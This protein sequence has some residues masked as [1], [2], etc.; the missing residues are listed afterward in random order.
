MNSGIMEATRLVRAGRVAEATALIQHALRAGAVTP[1]RPVDE[2]DAPELAKLIRQ[3]GVEPPAA[4]EPPASA[5]PA[6]EKPATTQARVR[7]VPTSRPSV[8]SRISL[9]QFPLPGLEGL[10]GR[11]TTCRAPADVTGPGQWIP[12]T[13]R[14]AAGTRNYKL[15][16]PSRYDG[17]AV[18]LV[19][20]LHGCTQTPDDFA[21][22]TG[23]NLVAEAEG[24]LVAYPAQAVGSNH[25]KC[26]N[27]F[28]A[29]HQRREEGEPSLIAGITRQVMAQYNVDPARVYI[30]G[31]SAGGAM[32]A[33]LAATYPDLYAAVGVHSGLAPGS[34]HDLPSALQAM[35]QG[36]RAELPR[37]ERVVPLILF[38]GDRD[39]TVRPCNADHLVAQW[40]TSADG[41]AAAP[42]SP[43]GAAAA[44]ETVDH[45]QAPGGRAYTREI[46]T[47]CRG[48]PIVECWTIHGA[49]HAWSGG[50]RSGTYTDPA[51]P[52]ASREL[53]RFFLEQ[54]RPTAEPPRAR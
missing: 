30:A 29:S 48:R 41:A 37:V 14:G 10:L 1:A 25:S 54:P 44:P 45:G 6:D 3:I 22:G 39:S 46:Y 33:I 21:A 32:A 11:E 5:T 17:R 19:I 15:Y 40:I 26:W 13:H 2:A 24:F 34:A 16:I 47:D 7:R 36:G 50:S 49:G 27:W 52:D 38:H 53:A 28:H 12:G 20:M 43:N 35:Q 31:L 23:M 9:D 18:P 51:G 8:S 42:P 4:V